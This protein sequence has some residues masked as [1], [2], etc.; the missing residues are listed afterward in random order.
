MPEHK[1]LIIRA[2]VKKPFVEADKAKKWLCDLVDEIGM[3]ITVNGGPHADYV[4]KEGNCGIAAIVMIETSHVAV[5]IWDKQQ[6]PL[7][8]MDVYSC[9]D[10]NENAVLAF[11]SEME[12]T[13]IECILIDRKNTLIYQSFSSSSL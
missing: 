6:P 9:S 1:H 8:Q 3:N 4:E 7:V 10:Y 13:K 12:P 5:H 11:L 2:E